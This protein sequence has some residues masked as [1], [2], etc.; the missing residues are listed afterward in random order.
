MYKIK[1]NRFANWTVA[2]LMLISCTERFSTTNKESIIDKS[3]I[4]NDSCEPPCWY[5]MKISKSTK[6]EAEFFLSQLP[7]V[8]AQSLKEYETYWIDGTI[9]TAIQYNCVSSRS[10]PCGIL[11]FHDGLLV[12]NWATVNYDV[13]IERVVQHLGIPDYLTYFYP[14][15]SQV[16]EISVI[17]IEK[18]I[19]TNI[20]DLDKHNECKKIINGNKLSQDIFVESVLYT[21]KDVLVNSVNVTDGCCET[22]KWTGFIND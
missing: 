19:S 18:G 5:D 4:T 1:F 3:L 2:V 13:T 16:C 22:I 7:F 6:K 11:T 15:P 9:A 12:K 10:K 17:W 14:N 8:E 20:V 21:S